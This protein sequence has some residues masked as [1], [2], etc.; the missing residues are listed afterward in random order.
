MSHPWLRTLLVLTGLF[1]AGTQPAGAAEP[2]CPSSD[3]LSSLADDLSPPWVAKL[4]QTEA[5]EMLS[6]I[7][8]GEMPDAGT[9]WFHPARSKY[10]WKWLA[11]RWDTNRDGVIT[12]D[13]F[14]GPKELFDRLDRNGDG[15]LTP[16]DFDWS[17][18]SPYWR[19]AGL[20][21]RLFRR[22]DTDGDGRITA[23]EWQVLFKQ[24]AKGK[25]ALTPDDL[26]ML[27]FPPPAPPPPRSEMPSRLTLLMGLLSGEI[28]SPAE[29]PAV[30]D[31]GPDFTLTT[32]DGKTEITLSQYRDK[33]PV[34][35]IFGS[36]T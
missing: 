31:M 2:P 27:L 17:D 12:R 8:S 29:G 22:A 3:F 15:N 9:G 21:N 18:Q 19:E 4:R 35:L 32:Q 26:R 13:E 30:G 25:D 24:A 23:E 20:A 6:S 14:T 36:F 5:A 33:K 1:L 10:D 28:G 34:V 11:A 16:D 7:L